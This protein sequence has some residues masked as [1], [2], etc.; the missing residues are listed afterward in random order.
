MKNKKYFLTIS[1]ILV[2]GFDIVLLSF[3]LKL[4]TDKDIVEKQ[5]MNL[6]IK[7]NNIQ[8]QVL[9]SIFSDMKRW[10]DDRQ[11]YTS[12]DT[13]KIDDLLNG[14]NKLVLWFSQLNCRSCIDAQ[15][16]MLIE[17]IEDIGNDNVLLI[18]TSSN[19]R[20]ISPFKR[21]N[22]ISKEVYSTNA[23]FDKGEMNLNIPCYF[24]IDKHKMISNVFYPDKDNKELTKRYLEIV[25]K[26]CLTR[27]IK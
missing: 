18:T 2:F 3:N 27:N 16:E 7:N 1:F 14:Q 26:K 20:I 11:L 4:K 9:Q 15:Y 10:D 12:T 22:S 13:I 6:I 8:K 23:E 24:V 17:M 25:A 19:A 5:N 21:V